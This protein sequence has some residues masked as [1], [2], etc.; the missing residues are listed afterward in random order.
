MRLF[1]LVIMVLC[2]LII[3]CGDKGPNFSPTSPSAISSKSANINSSMVRKEDCGNSNDQEPDDTELKNCLDRGGRIELEYGNPGYIVNGLNGD[4]TQGLYLTR[5]GTVLTSSGGGKAR[6]IA[7]RD[8]YAGILQTRGSVNDFIIENISFDGMVDEM[9]EDGPYRRRRED[10]GEQ[11]TPGNI[12][13][14]GYGFQFKNNESKNAMCGTGLGLYGKFDVQH[15]SIASNGRDKNSGG[16]GFPWADGMTVL[17]CDGGYIAH[18]VLVDNT[19]IDLVLGGGQGCVV[20]LNTIVHSGKY[21]FAGLNIGNFDS[22]SG[23][24][25]SGSEY[26][27]NIVYSKVPDHLGMGINVGSH[28]WNGQVNISHAGRVIA[29]TVY[30]AN[31]NMLVDGVYGGEIS[32]NN[33]YDPQGNDQVGS[34]R[35]INYGVFPPHVAN[36]VLQDDWERLPGSNEA[37]SGEELSIRRFKKFLF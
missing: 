11:G 25:H 29:N 4:P 20:E 30:G 8:L 1:S 36:T 7:G 22:P 37:C 14:I 19:D 18:N 33:I 16:A 32:G 26:R 9:A 24:D 6:I 27:G 34:C 3:A 21:A 17:Y 10:C 12:F 13:L 31:V 35:R 5:S 28:M 23:G 2:A 15:N